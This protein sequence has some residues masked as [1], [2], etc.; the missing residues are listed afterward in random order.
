MDTAYFLIGMLIL[1]WLALWSARGPKAA[2]RF[3]WPFDMKQ[4][5]DDPRIASGDARGA[6]SPDCPAPPGWRD[7]AA[8]RDPAAPAEISRARSG[9]RHRR[10]P[11]GG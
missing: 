4:P 9:T 8:Q 2:D 10:T 11:H 5:S 6:S 1:G 7:R 3:W